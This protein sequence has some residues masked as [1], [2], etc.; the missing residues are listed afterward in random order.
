MQERKPEINELLR[1]ADLLT[2]EQILDKTKN[3][4]DRR[5]FNETSA[6]RIE[7][8]IK[9]KFLKLYRAISENAIGDG[10]N[11]NIEAISADSE[12]SGIQETLRALNDENAV[13]QIEE[14]RRKIGSV[15][16]I[17]WA[18]SHGKLDQSLNHKSE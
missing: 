8:N 17:T 3:L 7:E 15:G 18:T 6:K 2:I 10:D 5:R 12:I 9:L 4:L 11:D 16:I 13:G 1:Q 14:F